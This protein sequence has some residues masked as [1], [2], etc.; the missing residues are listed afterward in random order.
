MPQPVLV[1]LTRG[2]VVES[3]HHGAIAVLDADGEIVFSTGD[4]DRPV[5]PRSAIKGFQALPLI[6]S[7]AAEAL[8]FGDAELALAISSH[9]GEPGHVETAAGMLARVGRDGTCLEC[10]AHWPMLNQRMR[11]A[12]GPEGD[13]A[14]F[15][16]FAGGGQP[17]PLHNNC[18]GKHAGF[19]CLAVHEGHD[20]KG[21]VTPE[22]PT[23]R[24][25]SAAIEAMT[26]FEL[27][28]APA[29]IDGCAIP[30]F[31][32]PLRNLAYGFARFATGHGLAP[33]R[34]RA[35]A[36]LRKAAAASPFHVAG[37]G[38]F[39][40][41]VMEALRE[42]AFVKTGAE[43]VYCAALPEQGLGVAL[44]IWDGTGRAAET[45]M[46]AMLARFLDMSDV[47]EKAVLPRVNRVMHNW[48]GTEVGRMRAAKDLMG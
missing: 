26:E 11:E 43:G 45:A 44:K 30:T 23:M 6:E 27:A 19:V 41:T 39:D 15:D 21:Y 7:G 9:S 37:T 29:G 36:R 24:S 40:T 42:K 25:V 10:G 16:L 12:K 8:G 47:E 48:N 38:R 31:G 3:Q 34:A 4:I 5:F 18:S 1:E 28:S 35:A 33:E 22:H 2:G 32:I 46:A 14:A 17:S 20:P 13:R